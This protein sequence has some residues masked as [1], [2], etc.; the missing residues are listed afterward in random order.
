[1]SSMQDDSWFEDAFG[2]VYADEYEDEEPEVPF[3]KRAIAIVIA[4]LVVLAMA[5]VPLWNVIDRGAPP[6]ADNGLEI[7]GWDYCLVQDRM[8]ELGLDGEMSALANT[9]L[10]DAEAEAYAL[11]LVEWLGEDPVQVQ[12][13]DRLDGRIAGQYSPDTRTI[14]LERPVRAWI[15]VHEAAHAVAQNHQE[16][17]I[18]VLGRLAESG[19]VPDDR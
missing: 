15:V 7:C 16:E 14:W 6:V 13:V 12:V 3:R 11:D 2:D 4:T 18:D 8:I 9:F 10:D 1:M 17:F 5:A 19:P